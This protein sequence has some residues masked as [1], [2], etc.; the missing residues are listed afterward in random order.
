MDPSLSLHLLPMLKRLNLLPLSGIFLELAL[1]SIQVYDRLAALSS[2]VLML[3]SVI[4]RAGN[5][6]IC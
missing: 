2:M 3:V 5:L 6:W 1:G 4:S